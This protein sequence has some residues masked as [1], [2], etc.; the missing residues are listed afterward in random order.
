MNNK[1]E[2]NLI[3]YK[4]NLQRRG[5]KISEVGYFK[6]ILRKVVKSRYYKL[7]STSYIIY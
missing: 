2:H 4:A 7:I 3:K 5:P 6:K 1:H